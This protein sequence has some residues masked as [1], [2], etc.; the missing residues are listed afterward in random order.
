[1]RKEP[2]TSDRSAFCKGSRE[3]QVNVRR[4]SWGAAGP[5]GGGAA[6]QACP[7]CPQG[8]EG[9][10]VGSPGSMDSS[11]AVQEDEARLPGG[12]GHSG[13]ANQEGFP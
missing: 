4:Q 12:D 9:A 2:L 5:Q 10:E 6:S 3:S 7:L 11:G 8:W 13:L 1:M